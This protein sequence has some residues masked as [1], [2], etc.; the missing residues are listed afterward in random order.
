MPRDNTNAERAT[1]R[2]M[3]D[4]YR[5]QQDSNSGF[6]DWGKFTA[7]V[8]CIQRQEIERLQRLLKN[9]GIDAGTWED[10]LRA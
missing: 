9:N 6:D 8:V 4:A 5:A 3:T 1:R 2:E 10:P 7:Y